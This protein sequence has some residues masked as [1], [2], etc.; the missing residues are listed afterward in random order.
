MDCSGS[1]RVVVVCIPLFL[2]M[3]APRSSAIRRESFI[4]K[5]I[6]K[7]TVQ[8]R[9]LL[10]DDNGHV[11]DAFSLDSQT[12]CCPEN[13][14]KFSCQGCS[15][16]SKCCNSYEYCVS[17]CLSPT[18]TKKDHIQTVKI[19]KPATA[20]TY[21]SVFE[22][23]AGRCRHNSESV[24]HE[25][26]YVSALHHCF[27][28]PSN[29]SGTNDKP[30]EAGLNGINVVV[31][32]KGEACDTV[33]KSIGQS[34]VPSKLSVLNQCEIMQK[35]M[36]CRGSCL[37]SVG[38]DQPAEVADDAPKDL[39]PGACL[40]TQQLSI[41]S[42]LS[43]GA[44]WASFVLVT[45]L[46]VKHTHSFAPSPRSWCHPDQGCYLQFVFDSSNSL[47]AFFELEMSHQRNHEAKR[48]KGQGK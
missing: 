42:S 12:R 22:F 8:G 7:N 19:A 14:E 2:S 35:Y 11:C 40:Y 46:G 41:L 37:A 21:S 47:D 15:L 45:D 16:L 17:C 27:S 39:N 31:G 10:S 43:L 5:H 24:I 33:C 29:H 25:N 44:C 1:C 36:S 3:F 30:F 38:S 13:G 4:E 34:C 48:E 23:C 6:C 18:R 32:R 9:Y 28:L 20:G 26:A